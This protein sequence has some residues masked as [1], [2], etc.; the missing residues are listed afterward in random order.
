VDL[1]EEPDSVLLLTLKIGKSRLRPGKPV[2]S[3]PQ[4]GLTGVHCSQSGT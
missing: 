2:R 1:C 3:G 4:G